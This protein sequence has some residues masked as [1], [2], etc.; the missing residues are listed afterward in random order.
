MQYEIHNQTLSYDDAK[1][2]AFATGSRLPTYTELKKLLKDGVFDR[3]QPFSEI[4]TN[5]EEP[6][7]AKAFWVNEHAKNGYELVDE[8]RYPRT[9]LT[10]V[11][12]KTK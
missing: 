5:K 6:K 1:L 4:W 9:R 7:Y 11:L 3:L 10:T 12:I 8:P 2:L